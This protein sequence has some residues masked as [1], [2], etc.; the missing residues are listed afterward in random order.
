MS[1]EPIRADVTPTFP[2]GGGELGALI[3]AFD[4]SRTSLGP[5]DCWPQSLKTVAHT[6]L[7]SPVPI[8]LLWGAEGVMIYN[9]AYSV[10]AGGRHP[11][12]LGS[13]VREG[14]P[15]VADFNANVMRIGLAG[16]TLAYR[17]QE[18]TLHRHG[19]PAPAWMNL[20][21]S[22]VPD[23]S[24]RPAGVIAI[25]VET[26]EAVLAERALTESEG[27]FRALV[28]A[29]SDVIY[30]MSADW[31][32]MQPLDGRGFMTDSELP[33]PGWMNVNIF[34]EDQPEII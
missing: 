20:D 30:Q 3:A 11:Q 4:W 5:L 32:V 28:S 34:P 22:P 14:W 12:L 2:A 19:Y 1:A 15:E 13:R 31:S 10:F 33:N 23:E 24:G 16:G 17:N 21:Y 6:L 25:V 7:L 26:T 27:R 9:D 29:T 18:L 8:V